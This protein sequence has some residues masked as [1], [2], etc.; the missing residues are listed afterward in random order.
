MKTLFGKKQFVMALL[1]VALSGAVFVNW[2][3]T[4]PESRAEAAAEVTGDAN[5][6]GGNLGDVQLV[7]TGS[8]TAKQYF[9]SVRLNRD[10][11]LDEVVETL[12]VVVA[13]A[14]G[15]AASA[16]V[17]TAVEQLSMNIKLEKDVEALVSAKTGGDCV[18]I[19][20]GRNME[21]V[22]ANE[23]LNDESVLQIKDIVLQNTDIPAE[24]IT[25][26]GVK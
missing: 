19:I 3:Y 20:N 23:A 4:R 5:E 17:K 6:A 12:K 9:A 24:K 26:I 16:E 25:I 7:S 13:S 21:V 2:Y 18:T 1:V 22:V 15:E 11:A 8:E 10:T 14:S